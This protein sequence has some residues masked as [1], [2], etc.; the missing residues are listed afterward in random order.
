MLA[1][2][3]HCDNKAI[4]SRAFSK[5]YNGKSR[6]VSLRHEYIRQLISKGIIAIIYVRSCNNLTDLFTKGIQETW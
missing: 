5:I 6:Y 2:S 1:I 4:I 3:L